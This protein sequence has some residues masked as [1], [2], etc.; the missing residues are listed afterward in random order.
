MIYG[1]FARISVIAVSLVVISKTSEVI[2]VLHSSSN[3]LL[4][5]GRRRGS[6][7]LIDDSLILFKTLPVK[8][9]RLALLLVS[10]SADYN[11]SIIFCTTFN[12]SSKE[13]PSAYGIC[14]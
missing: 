3:R 9:R 6:L 13:M 11:D 7:D 4:L 10:L 14:F 8:K 12:A 1:I 2:S 5:L